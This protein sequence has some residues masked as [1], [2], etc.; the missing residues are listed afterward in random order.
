MLEQCMYMYVTY[1]Q[2]KQCFVNPH[3]AFSM[4]FFFQFDNNFKFLQK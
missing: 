2:D 1:L 3:F 4:F